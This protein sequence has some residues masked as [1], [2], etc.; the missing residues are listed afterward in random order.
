MARMRLPNRIGATPTMP[1]I[2]ASPR[3]VCFPATAQTSRAMPAPEKIASTTIE[4]IS[5]IQCSLVAYR[6]LSPGFRLSSM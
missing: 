1:I 3:S 6:M 4:R 2:C 5:T